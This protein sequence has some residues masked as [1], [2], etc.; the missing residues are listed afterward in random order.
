MAEP[1]VC[2]QSQGSTTTVPQQRPKVTGS[3][4]LSKQATDAKS[5]PETRGTYQAEAINEVKELIWVPPRKNSSTSSPYYTA[6]WCQTTKKYKKTC[7][8][9]SNVNS[10]SKNQVSVDTLYRDNA[11]VLFLRPGNAVSRT[12]EN[13]QLSREAAAAA[14][15]ATSLVNKYVSIVH[16][17]HSTRQCMCM[18]GS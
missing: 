3:V 17:A 15:T 7:N 16:R 11:S 6:R 9:F 1:L 13:K 4:A 18:G 8:L 14:V 2:L 5:M 12:S 10:L